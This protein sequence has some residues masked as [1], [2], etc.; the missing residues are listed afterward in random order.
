MRIRAV[1]FDLDDTLLVEVASAEEAFR[2]TCGLAREKY[3][4]DPEAFHETLR[5]E[6]RSLWHASP[7]RATI[8]RISIS[9]WEGLWARYEGDDSD[10]VRLREWAVTY[11]QASWERAL[12]AYAIHDPGFAVSLSDEFGRQRRQRHRLFDDSLPTLNRLKRRFRL[13]LITNGLSC[14]QRE[15]IRGVHLGPFFDAVLIA[16]DVGAAKPDPRIFHALLERLQVRPDQ[17]IMVGNSVQGD[18]GGAQA[19]GMGAVLIHRG[20]V[21]AP[22]DSIIPDLTIDNLERLLEYPGLSGAFDE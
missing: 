19:V 8:E 9:H 3:G 16:G 1:V 15:K 18:I 17:A 14:L 20:R 21:H 6:A 2:A 13:G 7:E 4:L 5:R 22:D 12:R 11:R 10:M